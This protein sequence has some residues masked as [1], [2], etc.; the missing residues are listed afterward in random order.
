VF[1]TI[2][3]EEYDDLSTLYWIP[4]LH[5]FRER[6][7]TSST[8]STKMSI[9][10]TKDSVCSPRGILYCDNSYSPSS[11]NKMWILKNSKDLLDD[12]D[13]LLFND[14]FWKFHLSK[15][16]IFLHLTPPVS[17]KNIKKKQFKGNY[18]QH[19]LL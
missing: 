19:I 3:N 15:Y 9:T 4:K 13:S 5:T 6:Y 1:N 16:L 12:F 10:L 18:S 11:I 2:L 7:I 17:K 8:C 14:F